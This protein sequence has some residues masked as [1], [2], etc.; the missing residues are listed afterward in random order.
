[1]G[2][3]P[4][5]GGVTFR[6]WAPNARHV[7]VIGDFC[8]W[9]TTRK[10]MLA[11]DEARSGTWSAF[12]PGAGPG[13]EYR[14]LVR[15]GGPYLWRMDPYGRQVTGSRGNSVVFDPASLDW[16]DD[17]YVSPGWDEI[18][19]YELHV[20]TF[21]ADSRGPGTFDKAI[22]RLEHLAWLGVNAVELMPPFE[23]AGTVSW[24]TTRHTCSPSSRP[25][26]GRTRSPGSFARR[27]GSASPCSS[28][29]CTTI[30]APPT[31]TYGVSTAGARAGGAASTSTTT[32]G[33]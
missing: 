6:V 20:G 19:L 21:A 24:G 17:D 14:F 8:G 18:V 22:G 33:P 28:T 23:F 3:V 7:A 13:S 30:S 27:T 26:A 11:R 29:W 1:M 12:V 32:G 9:Q 31:S 25:L 5:D 2:A 10:Q 4:H 15:R 16:G